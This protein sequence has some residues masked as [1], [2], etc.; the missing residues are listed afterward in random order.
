MWVCVL[1]LEEPPSTEKKMSNDW[2]VAAVA[3]VGRGSRP[4]FTQCYFSPADVLGDP[5]AAVSALLPVTAADELQLHFLMH[6]S[7]DLCDEKVAAKVPSAQHHSNPQ[8]QLQQQALH[9]NAEGSSG[10]GGGSSISP[11]PSRP[12]TNSSSDARF[13]DKVIQTSRWTVHAF[14]SCTAVRVL[15]VTAGDAPREA[16]QP[17]CRHLHEA[18]ST[19]LCNPFRELDDPL[20]STRFVSAVNNILL[21]YSA[22]SRSKIAA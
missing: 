11:Q 18:S 15:L 14:H 21:P 3:I 6:S 1:A 8:Q 9:S 19:A 4:L 13:L 16:V 22:T 12:T 20:G 2:A 7:L 5:V 17:L 10:G